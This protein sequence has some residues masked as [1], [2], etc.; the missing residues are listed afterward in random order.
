VN[1][2]T[3]PDQLRTQQ[4]TEERTNDEEPLKKAIEE[5]KKILQKD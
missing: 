3:K 5:D 2:K 1:E 4:N